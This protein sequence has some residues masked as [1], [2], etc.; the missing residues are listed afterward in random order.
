MALE[1]DGSV[2]MRGDTGPG[3][4]VRIDVDAGRMRLMTGNEIVGDWAIE[5][6]GIHA[7]NDGF[8]IRAEGE[9]FILRTR[10]DAAL[11]EELHLA[12]ATPRLARQV[13]ARHPPEDRSGEYPEPLRVSS[14]VGAVGFA[15]AG[16][17]VIL[18]GTLLELA[19]VDPVAGGG[20]QGS[21]FWIAFVIA[22]GFMVAAALVMSIGL[23]LAPIVSSLVL[24]LTVI[25]FGIEVSGAN[26]TTG[27][28]AAY[29]FIA[30]G[31]VVGV[32]VLVSGSLRNPD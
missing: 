30:G 27:Q 4:S 2:R 16:A 22:G 25:L 13:A 15:V 32:A 20:D 18:G 12:A 23:R 7:V 21:D 26:P 10:D 28:L 11:A 1:L 8:A 3:V 29:G 5:N 17:L 9:E 31:L 19:P 6:I 14:R 24:T